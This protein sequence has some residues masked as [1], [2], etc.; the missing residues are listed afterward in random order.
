L[1]EIITIEQ[2]G[3]R[4]LGAVRRLEQVC[5]PKDAWPLWDIIGVLSFSNVVRLKAVTESGLVVG[6]VAGDIHRAE[7]I[8]WIATIGVLPEYQ[9]RGIGRRLLEACEAQLPT[10][11]VR[12]CV[13]KENMVAIGLYLRSG[14]VRISEWR[15]YYQDGADAVVMEKNL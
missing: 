4:D 3:W 13:R 2:A 7:G 5:F 12:L 6:F 1:S 14:Y 15:R 11:S 8:S 10:R 9:G